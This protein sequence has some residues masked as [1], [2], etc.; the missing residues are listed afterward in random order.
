MTFRLDRLTFL[1]KGKIHQKTV[2]NDHL[3]FEAVYIYFLELILNHVL[4]N[5]LQ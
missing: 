3:N 2:Q 1:K 5:K 4:D